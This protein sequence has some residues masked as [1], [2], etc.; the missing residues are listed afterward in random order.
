M[1]EAGIYEGKQIA[2]PFQTDPKTHILPR[3]YPED[4]LGFTN[5]DKEV[6]WDKLLE[7]CAAVKEKYGDEGMFPI[8]FSLHSDQGSTNA[9]LN[10]MFTNGASWISADGKGGSA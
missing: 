7:I 5:L 9:M 1:L 6:S 10:V 3:G 8:S 2:L 4:E